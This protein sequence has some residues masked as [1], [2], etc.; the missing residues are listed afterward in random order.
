MLVIEKL[1]GSPMFFRQ[2]AEEARAIASEMK[3]QFAR[4]IMIRLAKDYEDLANVVERF[5]FTEPNSKHD[6]G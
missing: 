3:H 5:H 2:R 1:R 4:D 6:Q